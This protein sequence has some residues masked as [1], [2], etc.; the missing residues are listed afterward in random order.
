[1][2]TAHLTAV[3]GEGS[4]LYVCVLADS[5]EFNQMHSSAHPSPYRVCG[6]ASIGLMRSH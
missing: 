6:S 5:I 4:V 1:M 2:L 3:L